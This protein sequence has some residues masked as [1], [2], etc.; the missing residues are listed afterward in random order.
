MPIITIITGLTATI[1]VAFVLGAVMEDDS[2][3]SM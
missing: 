1:F 2:D 3:E